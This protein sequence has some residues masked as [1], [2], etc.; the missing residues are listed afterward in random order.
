MS[1]PDYETLMLPVLESLGD[2]QEYVSRIE[3]KIVLI[4]GRQLAELMIDHGIGSTISRT[5][6]IRR[7]DSD[8]FADDET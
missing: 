5:Y 3:R 6:E 2:G 4:D 8:Y 1:I 7:V